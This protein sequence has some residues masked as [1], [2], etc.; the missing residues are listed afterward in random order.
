[1]VMSLFPREYQSYLQDSSLP[2][3]VGETYTSLQI[4][5]NIQQEMSTEV[6][7]L[8]QKF[9]AMQRVYLQSLLTS[10]RYS[11]H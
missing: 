9:R 2:L 11:L 10:S 1:M 4:R 6:S 8:S 7:E 5:K 3:P